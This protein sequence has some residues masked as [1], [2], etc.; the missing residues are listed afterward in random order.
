M[1]G[2]IVIKIALLHFANQDLLRLKL[3]DSSCLITMQFGKVPYFRKGNSNGL[4]ACISVACNGELFCNLFRFY[5]KS[6]FFNCSGIL[7]SELI[8]CIIIFVVLLFKCLLEKITNGLF[9]CFFHYYI[10]FF[11]VIRNYSFYRSINTLAYVI[12]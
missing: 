9:I 7:Y 11:N 2:G 10:I 3:F 12:F 6:F 8:S 1:V 5:I 4:F